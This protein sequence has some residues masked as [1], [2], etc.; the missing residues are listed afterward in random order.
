MNLEKY[1]KAELISKIEKL[2]KLEQQNTKKDVPIKN[3]EMKTSDLIFDILTKVRNLFLSLTI[4]TILM[5]I[6]KNY[7]S[8]RAVLKLAN[9]II[10]TIFGMSIFEAFGLGFLV[11]FFNELRSIFGSI[12]NYLTDTTFYNYLTKIFHISE[13]NQSVRNGYKK[14]NEKID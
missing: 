13:E 2:N 4:V 9:Y 1:T 3:K 7:K 5:K 12:I 6:F 8:V 14:P 11:K 10:L